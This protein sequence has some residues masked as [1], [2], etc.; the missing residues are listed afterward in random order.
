MVTAYAA[1]SFVILQLEEI[2]F[3]LRLPDPAM[4][5]ILVV[6]I[7]GFVIAVVFSWFF[8][9][10]WKGIVRTEDLEILPGKA[11]IPA[12]FQTHKSFDNSI[13][14]LPFQD[15]SPERDQEY[16]CDGIAEEIINMLANIPSLKVIARTSSFT[17]RDSKKDIREIGSLLGVK[18]VLEGSIR[19]SGERL[20][21]T[22]QLISTQD[23]SHL[24]SEKFD[25]NLS[26][27]FEIQEE[28][29]GSI[30]KKLRINLL[31]EL[32]APATETR[33]ESVSAYLL[34][35]RG[36]HHYQITR[37]KDIEQAI[38]Y[39]EEALRADPGFAQAYVAKAN[40]F[41]AL[42]F[43][44]NVPPNQVYPVILENI[45]KAQHAGGTHDDIFYL[46]G[47]SNFSYLWNMQ[48]AG[49]NFRKAIRQ[50]PS[51]ARTR[52]TY[53]LYLTGIGK[54]LDAIV[55]AEMAASLDPLS[56]V[57]NAMVANAYNFA[58]QFDQAIKHC[59]ENEKRFQDHFFFP[60]FK[61]FGL[62]GKSK[63]QE[64]ISEYERA[65]ELSGR[66]QLVLANLI[67]AQ[68]ELG[69]LQE[70]QKGIRELEELSKSTYVLPSHFYKAY[71]VLSE[72]ELAH[73]WLVQAIK[74]HDG[75]IPL[76]K[77]HPYKNLRIPDEP[78][79]KE[80]LESSGL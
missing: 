59:T 45:E 58:G 68:I 35:L 15:M 12:S 60:Y 20:R 18:T 33:A 56:A 75:F 17:F 38:S 4:I 27:I 52:S 41:W 66:A 28:I 22:A 29:S 2:L 65:L 79:Y 80:L 61:G 25:R 32:N 69:N 47:V 37:K 63:L 42:T 70:G 7:V 13:A 9:L 3:S 64:A 11:E 77:N 73:K 16:F 51:S 21:I 14:V 71:R 39:Y 62:H 72:N 8:D 6:L 24:W 43:W 76:I 78:R 49:I 40:A 30:A 26:D 67:V 50:N 46:K 1:F 55:E 53:S 23:G 54:H 57:Y 44:G 36:L 5:F 10:S 48:E 74:D 19:K 34:Y 31:E